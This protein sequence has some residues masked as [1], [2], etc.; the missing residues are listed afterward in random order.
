M[1]GQLGMW[2]PKQKD[3]KNWQVDYT[4]T[5]DGNVHNQSRKFRVRDD[6]TDFIKTSK[7]TLD[8]NDNVTHYKFNAPHKI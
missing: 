8:R 1:A 6:A 2:Q 3:G 7:N 4:I 5:L